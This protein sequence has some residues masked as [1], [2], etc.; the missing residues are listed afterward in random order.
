MRCSALDNRAIAYADKIISICEEMKA[1]L[2]GDGAFDSYLGVL[3]RLAIGL[4]EE[5]DSPD[6]VESYKARR[7]ARLSSRFDADD[8]GEEAG[9][10]HGNTKIP[11]G[12]CQREGISIKKGWTPQDAWNALEKKGYK[13]GDVYKE[14]KETGHVARREPEKKK[15]AGIVECKKRVKACKDELGSLRTDWHRLTYAVDQIDLRWEK[16]SDK[17][18]GM[19]PD[20]AKK[21]LEREIKNKEAEIERK[22]AELKEAKAEQS[23]AIIKK[24]PKYTDCK[25]IKQLES[26]FDANEYFEVGGWLD[27][28]SSLKHLDM[29]SAIDLAESVDRFFEKVPQMKGKLK[30]FL[31]S[32]VPYRDRY[33][34]NAEAYATSDNSHVTFYAKY[35]NDP[36]TLRKSYDKD[37]AT[38]WAPWG[39]T[40]KD[41]V[42]HEYAHQI[43]GYFSSKFLEQGAGRSEDKPGFSDI[44]L[45]RIAGKDAKSSDKYFLKKSVCRYATTDSKEFFAEAI[46]EYLASPH[47]RETARKVGAIFEEYLKRLGG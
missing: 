41:I 5:I 45:D 47:P 7:E 40:Y 11:F 15:P 38:G 20:E 27:G 24:Y 10:A 14:L 32:D 28:E 37:V 42:I 16:V 21:H 36:E 26:R 18:A 29:E 1:L 25:T 13:P 8:D 19:G 2:S 43:D 30:P 3:Q 9:G 23:A 4:G 12:L 31:V 34:E 44:V 39:T 33:E 6:A 22:K 46:T 35:Y 17:Y